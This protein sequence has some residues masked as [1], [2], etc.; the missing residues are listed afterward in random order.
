M[1]CHTQPAAIT[2]EGE[3]LVILAGQPNVGNS[4]LFMRLTGQYGTVS[5]Y[6]G[7]TVEVARGRATFRD[8]NPTL[9]DAPGVNSFQPLATDEN[10]THQL[11]LKRTISSR[12]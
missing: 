3:S 12:V 9:L 4:V 2:P 11:L 1:N 10:V 7:T 6:P 8:G 5:N